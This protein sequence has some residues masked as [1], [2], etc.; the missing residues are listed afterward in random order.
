MSMMQTY[1]NITK[2][3]EGKAHKAVIEDHT[4][5]IIRDCKNDYHA[6]RLQVI[7]AGTEIIA[8]FAGDFG[9]Y[10]MVEVGGEIH[11]V[12]IILEE[13]CNINF[14]TFDARVFVDEHGLITKVA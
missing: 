8:D 9:M 4:F 12:K 13:L 6:D 3:D 11:N 7:P 2:R 14:G 10:G 5:T 1:K